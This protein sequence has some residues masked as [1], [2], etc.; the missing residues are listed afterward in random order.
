[1]KYLTK[2]VENLN[3]KSTMD[4]ISNCIGELNEIIKVKTNWWIKKFSIY[5]KPK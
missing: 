4:D 1:M 3:E 2:S 5:S